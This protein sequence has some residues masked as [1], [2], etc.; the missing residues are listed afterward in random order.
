MENM[1][2]IDMAEVKEK[3]TNVAAKAYIFRCESLYALNSLP[4]THSYLKEAEILCK[5]NG[6][7]FEVLE[8]KEWNVFGSVFLIPEKNRIKITIY[9][10]KCKKKELN[11]HAGKIAIGLFGALMAYTE[12]HSDWSENCEKAKERIE[13][14]MKTYSKLFSRSWELS[15]SYTQKARIFA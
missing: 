9:K 2:V 10:P 4:E 5:N 3:I 11:D 12:T 6:I 15:K 8:S 1:M 13:N 7:M 14:H